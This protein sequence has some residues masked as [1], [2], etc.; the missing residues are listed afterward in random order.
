MATD[1]VMTVDSE[2]EGVVDSVPKNAQ[3]ETNLN[4]EFIL[5]VAGD[6]F[7]EVTNHALAEDL[8]KSGSKPVRS[9]QLLF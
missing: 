7:L 3:E 2:D 9:W 4:S 5:D 1:Y 8:V 6:P